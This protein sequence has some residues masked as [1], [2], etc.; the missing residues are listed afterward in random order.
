MKKQKQCCGACET[1]HCHE[2]ERLIKELETVTFEASI[3]CESEKSISALY[4][5]T[6]ADGSSW[7]SAAWFPRKIC[8]FSEP[9]RLGRCNITAP[10]WLIE[11][12]GIMDK[13]TI[14]K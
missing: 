1:D 9:T 5:K 4:Q 11:K 12:L 8:Q 10:V 3:R 14:V 6:S 13:L 2:E 7:M